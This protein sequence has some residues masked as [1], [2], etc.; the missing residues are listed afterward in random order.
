MQLFQFSVKA[1]SIIQFKPLVTKAEINSAIR[2][3]DIQNFDGE[4]IQW[5][6]S[7]TKSV[8]IVHAD[9][10]ARALKLIRINFGMN[11]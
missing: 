6:P 2:K 5:N 4:F 7:S 8:G 9:N 10:Q 11:G 1:N 3:F